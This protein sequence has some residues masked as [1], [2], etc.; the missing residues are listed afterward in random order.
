MVDQVDNVDASSIPSEARSPSVWPAAVVNEAVWNQSASKDSWLKVVNGV[1][2]VVTNQELLA[3]EKAN[4]E[5]LR[6][7]KL[8]ARLDGVVA[9]RTPGGVEDA[10]GT[11]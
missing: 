7:M 9:T 6:G 1:Q 2:L 3:W 5:K 11:P 10:T 8:R 4:H